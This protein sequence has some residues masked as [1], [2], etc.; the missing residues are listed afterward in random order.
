MMMSNFLLLVT[1]GLLVQESMADIV[2]T[3]S[4][5]AQSVQLGVT[6]SISCTTSQ[7]VS[8]YLHWYQ[9]KPGQ[10]PKLL[11]YYA[12]SRQSGIPDRFS[13]SG[14]G[15]QFTLKITG[16]QAEDAGDYYCQQSSS[17]PTQINGRCSSDSGSSSSMMMSNILLLVM[18]GLFAQESVA[19]I[20]LTQDPT[21]WSAQLGDTVSISCTVSQSVLGGNFLHWYQQKP[22]QAPKLLI[23]RATS[24]QSGIPDRFSGSGSGTQFTLKIT[25][26][27]AED[28]GDYYCQSLHQIGGIWVFTQ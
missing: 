21:A 16:V 5:A 26:V 7:S 14:S 13:G 10:A 3:Q 28:A 15:T 6:V 19:D 9:Q 25:G 1:L 27:Q 11:V 22:G 2:L 17:S 20:V 18:L 8:N 23:Y 4:P 12:T 24:L